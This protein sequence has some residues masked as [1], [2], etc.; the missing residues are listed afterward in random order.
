M[1][2]VAGM[3][4][5]QGWAGVLSVPFLALIALVIT[6]AAFGWQLSRA[7]YVPPKLI[8]G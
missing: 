1:I 2:S 5:S 3:S 4:S 8:Y 7:T 6:H